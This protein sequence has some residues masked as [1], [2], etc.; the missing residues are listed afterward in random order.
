MTVKGMTLSALKKGLEEETKGKWFTYPGTPIRL[1]IARAGSIGFDKAFREIIKASP[2]EEAAVLQEN[3]LA[4]Q[5]PAVAEFVLL[6]WEGVV[7]ED[8]SKV[9]YTP[10][11]GLEMF[12]DES[13]NRFYKFVLLK[14]ESAIEWRF[15]D[16]EKVLENS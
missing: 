2:L 9:S 13:C 4:L 8:G 14:S 16:D 1:K 5:K 6:D 15:S 10:D 3:L 11:V 12:N 7:E